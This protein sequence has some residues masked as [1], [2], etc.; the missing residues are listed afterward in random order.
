MQMG[1][2]FLLG[3]S[4]GY[5]SY[6]CTTFSA[7]L[8]ANK[9]EKEIVTGFQSSIPAAG[10]VGG[11]LLAK[12]VIEHYLLKNHDIGGAGGGSGGGGGS[13]A[14]TAPSEPR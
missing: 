5:V 8:V 9:K 14:A 10:I 1:T 7:D 6:M 4:M 12:F 13:G 3:G 11:S 2:V